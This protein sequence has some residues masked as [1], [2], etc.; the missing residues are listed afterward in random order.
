MLPRMYWGFLGMN[1]VDM[2][3]KPSPTLL[4]KSQHAKTVDVALSTN[5]PADLAWTLGDLFGTNQYFPLHPY[6]VFFH[7]LKFHWHEQA[8]T[9]WK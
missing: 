4:F 8:S 9:Y 5:V 2:K 1:S 6:S 7:P 3:W